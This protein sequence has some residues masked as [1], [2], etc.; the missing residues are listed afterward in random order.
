[1]SDDREVAT[2]KDVTGNQ[3]GPSKPAPST[4]MRLLPF[5]LWW[6]LIAGALVG[7]GLR[8]FFS[9][10]PDS[11]FSAMS[12]AFLY[13]APF[14][15]GAVTVFFMERTGRRSWGQYALAG[16]IA[17]LLFISG[18]MLF[19]IEGLICAVLIAPLFAI[20]G[21]ISGLTMGAICRLTNWP[22]QSAY[23]FVALPVLMAFL[24]PSGAGPTRMHEIERTIEIAATSETV[25]KHLLDAPSIKRDEVRRAWV[26]RIGVPEPIAGTTSQTSDGRLVRA[27]EMGKS[28]HFQQVAREW[29][30]NQFVRW[31]YVF[32]ADSIPP[33][34]L[35]DHV[36]IGGLYFDLL[37]TD[38]TLNSLPN[39]NTALSI[40]MSYRVSTQLNWYAS[41]VAEFLIG[42]FGDVIL[43]FYKSR[44]ERHTS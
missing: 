19:L 43:E 12:S 8:L 27:I 14:A 32:D 15:V 9:G 37:G 6:P 18:T 2:S 16:A 41:P 3:S 42:N 30:Q 23:G 40:R 29:K 35:D 17:D 5:S 39:G 38:Y 22:K 25:W 33:M 1:M 20:I 36:K 26:Y 4:R 7:I 21:A 11:P 13:F 10:Q 44:A 28:I 31:N 24:L 34:A